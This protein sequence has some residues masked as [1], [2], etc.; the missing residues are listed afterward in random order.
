MDGNLFQIKLQALAKNDLHKMLSHNLAWP[1]VLK[2][3][4]GEGLQ[5]E[6]FG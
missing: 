5:L 3:L 2:V 1:S 6:N 4:F